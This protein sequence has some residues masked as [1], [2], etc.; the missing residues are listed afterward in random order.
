M[1]HEHVGGERPPKLAVAIAEDHGQCPVS[2]RG[3][4]PSDPALRLRNGCDDR[5]DN[6]GY[7]LTCWMCE[8]AP[9]VSD[10]SYCKGEKRVRVTRCPRRCR[11]PEVTDVLRAHS[12]ME[13]G[14]LPT[15]TGWLD[16]PRSGVQALEWVA[17][18]VAFH[19]R[20]KAEKIG[21]ESRSG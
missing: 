18:L 14:F 3:G 8:G 20:R 5:P 16:L 11:T 10:C 13:R 12:W 17:R 4:C 19:E 15:G 21:Q 2:C 6:P 9:S 7:L 1:A